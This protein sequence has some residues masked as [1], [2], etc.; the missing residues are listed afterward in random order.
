[1]HDI[2]KSVVENLVFV[3]EVIGLII[4]AINTFDG[5]FV[6]IKSYFKKVKKSPTMVIGEGLSL[7]L[8]FLMV[9][10]ALKTLI[11]SELNSLITLGLL[12][13]LRAGMS[14]LTHWEL[15]QE[16]TH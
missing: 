12:M 10:E 2:F 15:K 1:M 16:K 7:G 9:G 5:L 4:I 13:I 8:T 3:I 14:L 6:Y 11:I